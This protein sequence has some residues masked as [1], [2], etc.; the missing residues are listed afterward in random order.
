MYHEFKE[1][2]NKM[3]C[4]YHIDIYEILYEYVQNKTMGGDLSVSKPANVRP[5]GILDWEEEA[6]IRG[7]YSSQM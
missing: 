2:N 1:Y 6:R 5:G 4:E 7:G 3:W